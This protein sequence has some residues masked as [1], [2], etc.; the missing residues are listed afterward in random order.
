MET[1][2]FF[3]TTR[4]S[5]SQAEVRRSFGLPHQAIESIVQGQCHYADTTDLL[6]IV[7]NDV[8]QCIQGRFATLSTSPKVSIFS[9]ED[10]LD[11]AMRGEEQA[12]WTQ[13]ARL[14]E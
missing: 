13:S 4:N 12:S 1:E 9:G 8:L 14:L 2:T 6:V 5:H 11:V 10:D 3:A 7:V